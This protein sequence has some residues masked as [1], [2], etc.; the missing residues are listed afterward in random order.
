MLGVCVCVCLRREERGTGAGRRA[1]EHGIRISAHPPT[2]LVKRT[3]CSQTQMMSDGEEHGRGGG[4]GEKK[5]VQ[6]TY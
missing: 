2:Y 1:E 4:G 6:C 3:I 5:S